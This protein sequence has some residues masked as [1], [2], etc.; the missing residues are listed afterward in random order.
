[1]K[2]LVV[3]LAALCTAASFAGAAGAADPAADLLKKCDFSRPFPHL[4]FTTIP[5]GTAL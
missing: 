4:I 2:K 5:P 1:M 3:T